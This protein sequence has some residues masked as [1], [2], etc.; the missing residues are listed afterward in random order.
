MEEKSEKEGWDISNGT[1]TGIYLYYT[2]KKIHHN[3]FENHH[4]R[5]KNQKQQTQTLLS[6]TII[7][8]LKYKSTLVQTLLEREQQMRITT[9]KK[10]NL[11][12]EL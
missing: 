9:P 4:K 10:K 7:G 12:Y 6:T 1:C 8:R 11:N 3:I 5:T 2:K